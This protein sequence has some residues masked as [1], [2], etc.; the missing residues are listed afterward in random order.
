MGGRAP[1]L[2]SAV[3]IIVKMIHAQLLRLQKC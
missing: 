1:N 2:T 3:R